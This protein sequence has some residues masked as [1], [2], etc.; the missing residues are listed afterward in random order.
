MSKAPETTKDLKLAIIGEV[1]WRL[2]IIL[3]S[4]TQKVQK[5][6]GYGYS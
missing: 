2:G 6:R 1:G 3:T 5:S 4:P